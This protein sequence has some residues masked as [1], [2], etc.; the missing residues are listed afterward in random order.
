[1]FPLLTAYL[2]P[3]SMTIDWMKDRIVAHLS[4]LAEYFSVCFKNINM[5]K[6]DWIR[7]V[8]STFAMSSCHLSRKAEQELLDL[9]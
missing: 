6:Y 2:D 3:N 9:L 7:A 5:E 8:F 1:M 4:T